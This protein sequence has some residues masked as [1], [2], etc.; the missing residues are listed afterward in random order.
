MTVMKIRLPRNIQ[1]IFFWAASLAEWGACVIL[2]LN[3]LYLYGSLPMDEEWMRE[4]ARKDFQ[5]GNI[6]FL[7]P[8]PGGTGQVYSIMESKL[9][10]RFN[11]RDI[12][13]CYYYYYE[14]GLLRFLVISPRT[15]ASESAKC[16]NLEMK[17]LLT[18]KSKL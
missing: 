12:P 3:L 4:K 1:H 16:Y 15:L 8:T 9:K 10:E 11:N 17:T 14:T 5:C 2:G 6:R 13:I 7:R 18:I